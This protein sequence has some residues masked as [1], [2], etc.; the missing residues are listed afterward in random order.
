MQEPIDPRNLRYAEE[1]ILM[2]LSACSIDGPHLRTRE[3]VSQELWP[4]I[5]EQAI[6][7][8]LEKGYTVEKDGVLDITEE[9]KM[10]S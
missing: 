2:L 9:G 1:H 5:A 8:L 7:N 3:V 10:K 4:H 6:K